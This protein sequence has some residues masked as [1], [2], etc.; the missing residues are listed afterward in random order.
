MATHIEVKQ[1]PTTVQTALK[2]AGYNRR[3]IAVEP[4]ETFQLAPG[5]ADGYRGIA[6]AINMESGETKSFWGSWGGANPFS[7]TQVDSDDRQHAIPVNGVAFVGQEGGGKPTS[8]R[9]YVR[10]DQITKVLPPI[11][12]TITE[13][14]RSILAIFGGIKSGYRAEYLERASVSKNELEWLVLNGFLKRNK[15]GS[16][17]ITPKGKNSRNAQTPR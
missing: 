17:Q 5:W 15:A 14:D 10:P 8:G 13:R 2:T 12:E 1:L 7:Q 9:L 11:D 4:S 16:L 3:D 6:V